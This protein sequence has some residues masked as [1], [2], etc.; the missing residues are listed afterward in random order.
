MQL[1]NMLTID[2]R[3]VINDDINRN[4]DITERKEGLFYL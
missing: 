4:E 2:N 1:E 3:K